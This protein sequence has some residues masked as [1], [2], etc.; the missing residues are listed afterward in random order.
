[1]KNTEGQSDHLHILGSS[2]C[3]DVAGLGANV[4]LNG[5]LQPGDQKVSSLTNGVGLDSLQ[6]VENDGA[7]SSL[8]CRI[9]SRWILI[10]V[11]TQ[12]YQSLQVLGSPLALGRG[13]DRK[14]T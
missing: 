5:A 3:R 1:V 4:E 12:F 2:C 13:C 9:M 6:S 10:V 11:S 14:G 7:M 8:N